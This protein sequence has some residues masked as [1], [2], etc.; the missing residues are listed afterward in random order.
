MIFVHNDFD[1][2]QAWLIS[3]NRFNGQHLCN[4]SFLIVF[5]G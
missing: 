3:Y 2:L 4:D 5:H 1:M